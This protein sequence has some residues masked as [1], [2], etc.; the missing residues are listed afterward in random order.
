ML[1]FVYVFLVGVNDSLYGCE[2]WMKPARGDVGIYYAKQLARL[3]L[4]VFHKATPKTLS[5]LCRN[6][7]V[8]SS[9]LAVVRHIKAIMLTTFLPLWLEN[10]CQLPAFSCHNNGLTIKSKGNSGRRYQSEFYMSVYKPHFYF[11]IAS[12]ETLVIYAKKTQKYGSLA[13]EKD[14]IHSNIWGENAHHLCLPEYQSTS[15]K[16]DKLKR[17]LLF[18]FFLYLTACL[19]VGNNNLKHDIHLNFPSY[20]EK[21]W[22]MAKIAEEIIGGSIVLLHILRKKSQNIPLLCLIFYHFLHASSAIVKSRFQGNLF[23]FSQKIHILE[24]QKSWN[25]KR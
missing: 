2:N 17:L 10:D 12:K 22:K 7:S 24:S 3:E 11:P 14:L 6:F 8:V 25:S 18:R 15:G 4:I 16:T 23:I 21:H 19:A 13:I 20:G 1:S 5:A 9:T